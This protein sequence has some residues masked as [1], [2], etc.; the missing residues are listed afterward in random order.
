M[1]ETGGG[2]G[3]GDEGAEY[4]PAAVRGGPGAVRCARVHQH[5]VGHGALRVHVER[6]G[7]GRQ[8]DA[9]VPLEADE[10]F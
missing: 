4:P 9:G 5:A 7:G 2:D 8:W 10:K 6:P 3:G 1:G